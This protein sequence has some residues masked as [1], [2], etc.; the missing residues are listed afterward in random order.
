MDGRHS[1]T[2]ASDYKRRGPTGSGGFSLVEM[3]IAT[4]VFSFGMGGMAAL[5]LSSAGGMA[6]AEHHSVAHLDAAA[7]AATLQLSPAALEHVANP[8]GSVPL[9]F[10][11][12]TCTAEE[13]LNSQYQLWRLGI[14]RKLPNGSGVVCRDSTPMDGDAMEPGC[15]GTGPAVTKVFWEETRHS[16]DHDGGIRRVVVQVSQ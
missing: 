6:E 3:L 10:E 5:M 16:H 12:S 15:D 2:G 8:P 14:Q 4:T 13:W 9:C 1:V 11:G 7:M